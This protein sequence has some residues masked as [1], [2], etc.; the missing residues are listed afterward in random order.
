VRRR[1]FSIEYEPFSSWNQTRNAEL[2]REKEREWEREKMYEE[3]R[4]QW[5]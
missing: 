2:E 1:E 4:G 5:N 3:M